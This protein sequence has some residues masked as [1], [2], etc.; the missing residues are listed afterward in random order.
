MFIHSF[1]D[2]HLGYSRVLAIVNN[3]AMNRGIQLSL[4]DPAFTSLGYV[5]RSEIIGSYDT[6]MF[7][8]LQKY[9]TVFHKDYLI[10]HS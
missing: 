8:F 7:N 9:P 3:A 5:P 10:L 1:V 4:Q 2:G 6:S